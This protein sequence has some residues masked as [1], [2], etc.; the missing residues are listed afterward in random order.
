MALS[1]AARVGLPERP[2]S[3]PPRSPPT[4]S[5]LKVVL[6]WMAGTTAPVSGSGSAPACTASVSN[7]SVMGPRILSVARDGRRPAGG[8]AGLLHRSSIRRVFA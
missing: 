5:C 8:P 7:R 6:I 4:P 3:K 2:Y 1:R